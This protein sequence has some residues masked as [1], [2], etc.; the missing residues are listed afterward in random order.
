MGNRGLKNGKARGWL[1]AY[2][3]I[4][5]KPRYPSLS[6]KYCCSPLARLAC[7]SSSWLVSAIRLVDQIRATQL[8]TIPNTHARSGHPS[9]AKYGIWFA[10]AS[11][12]S[13]CDILRGRQ[14]RHMASIVPQQRARLCSCMHSN[15]VDHGDSSIFRPQYPGRLM[16]TP[17]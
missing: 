6:Y 1:G 11:H 13:W 5:A 8:S 2:Y 15:S 12:V 9:I 3:R 10:P 4:L 7:S 16:V 14:G 17:R